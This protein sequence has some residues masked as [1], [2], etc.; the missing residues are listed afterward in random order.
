MKIEEGGRLKR[1]KKL[2]NMEECYFAKSFFI[3][4]L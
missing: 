4:V 1:N 2:W 3:A